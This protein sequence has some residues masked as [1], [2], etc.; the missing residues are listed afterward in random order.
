MCKLHIN[1]TL[2]HIIGGDEPGFIDGTF[3]DAQYHSLQGVVFHSPS[4]LNVA[5]T[6]NHAIRKVTN[7]VS[8]IFQPCVKFLISVFC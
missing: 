8:Y 5:D 7:Q 4:L 1:Y 3:E 2:Q 6:E